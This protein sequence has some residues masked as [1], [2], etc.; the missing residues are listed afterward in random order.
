MAVSNITAERLRE[1]L[2]FDVE[3]GLFTRLTSTN[4]RIKPGVVNGCV[5]PDGYILIGV[6]KSHFLA[7]RLAW[8]YVHGFWPDQIDHINGIKHDNRLS[9]LRACCQAENSQNLTIRKNNTS[10]FV[11]VSFRPDMGKFAAEIGV[12]KQKIKLGLFPTA[13]LA[14]EAY[15]SAKYKHHT[16]QRTVRPKTF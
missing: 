13:E 5:R 8:F 1:L 3:T 2:S 6:E 7:H 10:G 9:N 16:F 12:N 15:A 4:R 14:A 11:G